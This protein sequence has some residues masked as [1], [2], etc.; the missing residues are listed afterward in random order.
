M[1]ASEET[2]I[3][4]IKLVGRRVG[5]VISVGIMVYATGRCLDW[6]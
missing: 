5:T 1:G 2:V 4:A 6:W 3:A